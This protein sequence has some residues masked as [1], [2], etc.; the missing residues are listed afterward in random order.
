MPNKPYLEI[1]DSSRGGSNLKIYRQ[2]DTYPGPP[3]CFFL[4]KNDR[5]LVYMDY[6][7]YLCTTKEKCPE[8]EKYRQYFIQGHRESTRNSGLPLCG[9][10]LFG[11]N[12]SG[13]T[14]G[15]PLSLTRSESVPKGCK[16][17]PKNAR[18]EET[19]ILYAAAFSNNRP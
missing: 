9:Y 19:T 17:Q 5:T 4:Q 2:K 18:H 1:Y 10:G 14:G 7:S 16:G 3:C 11:D 13:C 12:P 15:S 8:P 6:Y